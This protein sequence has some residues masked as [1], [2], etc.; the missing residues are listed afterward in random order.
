MTWLSATALTALVGTLT[1]ALFW[2][3][4]SRAARIRTSMLWTLAP[5]NYR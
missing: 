4:Q 3:V 5:V 1:V 2:V